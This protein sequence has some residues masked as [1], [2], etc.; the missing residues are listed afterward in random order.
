LFCRE[1][2]SFPVAEPFPLRRRGRRYREALLLCKPRLGFFILSLARQLDL[3]F[4]I[5]DRGF[6]FI[7]GVGFKIRMRSC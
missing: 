4:K 3:I 2:E 6:D 5:I 1:S 7:R